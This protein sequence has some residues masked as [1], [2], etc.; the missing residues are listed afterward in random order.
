MRS[1]SRSRALGVLARAWAGAALSAA[2]L[3]FVVEREN[4]RFMDL[5]AAPALAALGVLG[6]R[7]TRAGAIASVLASALLAWTLRAPAAPVST[8]LLVVGVDGATFDVIDR[9]ELGA[10]EAL[11]RD[12]ARATLRSAEPMFSPILWTTMASGRVQAEHGIR[13]FRVHSDDC[14]VA[15]WW[16]VA[17]ASGLSVGLYKWL[18]DYPPRRFAHGGFWVP[19]WLAPGPETWPAELGVVKEV[20]LSRRLWRKQVAVAGKALDQAWRLAR[21][22]ARASTLVRAA[23][24]SARAALAPPSARARDLEMQLLRG[25]L[26]RDIFVAWLSRVQPAIA[27]F[28]YYATDGLSHLYWDGGDSVEVRAAYAQAD[29][30]VGDLRALLGP[31]AR[32]IVVSDHGFRAVEAGAARA[33]APTTERLRAYLRGQG[34]EVDVSRLGR[35]LL[36]AARDAG[37]SGRAREA[38]GAL[39]GSDGAPVFAIVDVPGDP[40]AFGASLVVEE[41]DPTALGSASIAGEPLAPWVE[42]ADR[43][44]GTHDLRGVFYAVGAGVPRG[45]ALPDLEL[46]DVAPTILAAL[47]LPPATDMPGRAALFPERPRVGSYDGLVQG[48]QWLGGEQGVDEAMLRALGYTE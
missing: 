34:I 6:W 40:L 9:L 32:M 16:D 14:K 47:D 43:Y 30:I 48:F 28:T 25:D 18:V 46:L 45:V 7:A 1:A 15:R 33:Y 38:V 31:G 5:A 26:D 19:S 42:P 41:M 13:G 24:W 8:R 22:G 2:V 37:A 39:A 27:S 10:F 29:R 12:G 17:E 4:P 23:A 3:A 44:T 21:V 20:E 35:K 11:R 36:V